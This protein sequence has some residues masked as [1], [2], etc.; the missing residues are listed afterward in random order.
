[1]AIRTRTKPI[2]SRPAPAGRGYVPRLPHSSWRMAAVGVTAGS[3]A[4]LISAAEF[5]DKVGL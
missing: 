2:S 1:M 5:W 4:P 3:A